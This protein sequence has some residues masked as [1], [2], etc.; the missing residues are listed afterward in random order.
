MT[1]FHKFIQPPQCIQPPQSTPPLP[2][3]WIHPPRYERRWIRSDHCRASSTP[4][5]WASRSMRVQRTWCPQRH[6]PACSSTFVRTFESGRTRHVPFLPPSVCLS[7]SPISPTCHTR[8]SPIYIYPV[9][10]TGSPAM[11]YRLVFRFFYRVFFIRRQTPFSPYGA[12]RFPTMSEISSLFSFFYLFQE[13]VGGHVTVVWSA[14][15]ERPSAL[16]LSTGVELNSEIWGKGVCDIWE[17]GGWRGGIQTEDKNWVKPRIC[18]R[19]HVTLV[20]ICSHMAHAPRLLLHITS[21]VLCALSPVEP[22]S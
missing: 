14:S 10:I 16:E 18:D 7:F 8:I 4:T 19:T 13:R 12:P 3:R 15:V 5:L 11:C 22:L 9:Y 6:V 2:P 21:D 20:F 17:N 1:P